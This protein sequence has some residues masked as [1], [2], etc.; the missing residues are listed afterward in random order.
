[1]M[2]NLVMS[3]HAVT[4]VA[5]K[6]SLF[7]AAIMWDCFLLARIQAEVKSTS[8]RTLQAH[9][10]VFLWGYISLW[11]KKNSRLQSSIR[12]TQES[13]FLVHGLYPH[14]RHR[15]IQPLW[16]WNSKH[17]FFRHRSISVLYVWPFLFYFC[18][19]VYIYM[20]FYSLFGTLIYM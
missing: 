13:L 4:K 5:V 11:Y 16:V 18:F 2:D 7:T 10:S 19:A 9:G 20:I 17:G 6:F 3:L 1:M 8:P 15:W 14:L 12:K